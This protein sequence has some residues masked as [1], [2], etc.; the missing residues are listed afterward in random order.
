MIEHCLVLRLARLPGD[1]ED[2]G[3]SLEDSF[4]SGRED[5]ESDESF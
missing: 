4:I 1:E 3:V 5:S 2:K